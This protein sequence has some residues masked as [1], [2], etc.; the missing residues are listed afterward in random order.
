MIR[1][2][3]PQG[4]LARAPFAVALLIAA[5]A[6]GTGS[7]QGM[8]RPSTAPAR[9]TA[10]APTLVLQSQ[11]PWVDP[12][13]PSTVAVEVTGAPPGAQLRPVLHDRVDGRSELHNALAGRSLPP[14]LGR[15]RLDPVP[16][17]NTAATT[18]D[19]TVRLTT[20]GG[21]L[22]T[23]AQGG[24]GVYPLELT[25]VDV[26]GKALAAPFVTF[27]LLGPT[28]G[29]PLNV[30]VVLPVGD[31]P[32][33]DA[34]GKRTLAPDIHQAVS[35]LVNAL[36]VPATT[37]D[38]ATSTT[39]ATPTAPATPA[40]STDFPVTLAP[41][42]D[43]IDA[44]AAADH[45][46][47]DHLV[48]AATSP[49]REVLPGPYVPLDEAALTQDPKGQ[50]LLQD[51]LSAGQGPLRSLTP[52]LTAAAGTWLVD[53]DLAASALPPLSA[54][55]AK[56][57]LVPSTALATNRTTQRTDTTPFTLAGDPTG[58]LRGV[59]LDTN[60][61]SELATADQRLGVQQAL[62]DVVLIAHEASANPSSGDGIALV[63]PQG[64][65]PSADTLRALFAG[66]SQ[67]L[68][69]RPVTVDQLFATASPPSASQVA[70][71]TL[72][73][74]PA[75]AA[76][77]V[78]QLNRSDAMLASFR[79]VL[80]ANGADPDVPS[81]AGQ[82]LAN[83]NVRRLT[84]AYQGF[85]P[86]TQERYLSHID[87][88][89]HADL[90]RIDVPGGQ[91]VTL[92]SRTAN[93]PF[94]IHNGTGV[95][96]DVV[97][98]AEGSE[99][100]KFDQGAQVPVHIAGESAPVHIRVHVRTSGDIPIR[101]RVLTPDQEVEIGRSTITIRSTAVSGVGLFLTGG[102]LAFLLVWWA[103]HWHRNRRRRAWRHARK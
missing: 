31:R 2:H 21:P 81:V 13:V 71:R 101:L 70:Q 68:T 55:G 50:Q 39:P 16:V 35:D 98:E 90:A 64:W 61:Q 47:Y 36:G 48:T 60:L 87:A 8:G 41:V 4:S 19:V 85:D 27:L 88:S 23:A 82:R 51:E 58:T 38:P 17:D 89:V 59:A 83:L 65:R 6:F 86:A 12:T 54:L 100:V 32:T 22:G 63:A 18:V 77:Y 94:T 45:E 92:T 57:L 78:Q 40:T 102:A 10:G 29:S 73:G 76:R 15:G 96:V 66:L 75:L 99:R 95:P 97:V 42:P 44:L 69:I 53:P 74:K 33:V 26:K 46:L 20:I 52:P 43:T 84:S 49:G 3:R 103:R 9:A 67:T 7:V 79:T 91:K 25:L 34:E 30:A 1:P 14:I 37:S 93:I 80:T 56:R 62:A 11:P 24:P 28:A 72:I 5:L